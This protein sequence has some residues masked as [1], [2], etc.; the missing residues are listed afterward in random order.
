MVV[1]NLF[2]PSVALRGSN[3]EIEVVYDTTF[4]NCGD[5][6]SLEVKRK[7]VKLISMPIVHTE[8]TEKQVQRDH[9]LTTPSAS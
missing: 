8:I 7:V 4:R 3:K 6:V 5:E 1:N 2:N 9:A